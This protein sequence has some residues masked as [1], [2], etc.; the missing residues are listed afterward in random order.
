MDLSDDIHHALDNWI[1]RIAVGCKGDFELQLADFEIVNPRVIGHELSF[2][3]GLDALR[4]STW[5]GKT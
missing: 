5:I 3:S 2:P 4:D 1:H